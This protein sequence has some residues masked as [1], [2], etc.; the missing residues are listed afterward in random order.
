MPIPIR[1]GITGYRLLV[2]HKDDLVLFKNIDSLGA[3]KKLKVGTIQDESFSKILQQHGLNVLFTNNYEGSFQMLSNRRF[4]WMARGVHEIF[5]ELRIY[6]LE[7]EMKI[8]P[9][10]M[11]YSAL[12]TYI[13]VSKL[14]PRL[15]E[16]LIKG[17]TRINED[18]QLAAL[19][20]KYY[21]DDIKKAELHKRK[22][23]YINNPYIKNGSATEDSR[24]W[25][26]MDDYK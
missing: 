8:V 22:V 24:F 4:K 13:Y 25:F 6:G 17:L 23:I 18:G 21:A 10:L 19:F 5:D 2:A 11:L 26:S 1:G 9:D 20:N 3:L 16:R 15:A 12:P 14:H 7:S